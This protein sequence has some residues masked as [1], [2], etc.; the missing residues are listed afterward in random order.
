MRNIIKGAFIAAVMLAT[1]CG[2]SVKDSDLQGKWVYTKV[3]HLKEN[4]P[5][6]QEGADLEKKH[7][8]LVIENGNRL[9]IFSEDKILST[10][11]YVLDGN[12]IR[13]Q[14]H[15]VGGMKRKIPFLI[16]NLEGNRLT[17]ETMDSHII[18]VVAEKR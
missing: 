14:E 5:I 15:L 17:F 4:P 12:I 6:I 7:P 9:T 11:E 10:G 2:R 1:A 18:Q 3:S 8:Y 16:K 13:Y